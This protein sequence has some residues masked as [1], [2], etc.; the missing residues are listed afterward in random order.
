M[1]TDNT[2][3]ETHTCAV[4]WP[5]LSGAEKQTFATLAEAQEQLPLYGPTAY[6]VVIEPVQVPIG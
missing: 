1:N 4:E 2:E 3:Y 6:I 5:T